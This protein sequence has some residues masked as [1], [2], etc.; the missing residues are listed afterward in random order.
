MRLDGAVTALRIGIIPFAD[1]EVMHA[2]V[3]GFC[4]A[5]GEA[6]GTPVELHRAPDYRSLVEAVE[7]GEV[8]V[9]WVPP[10]VAARGVRSGTIRPAAVA[11][12]NGSAGYSTAL[13]TPTTSPIKRPSDLRAARVAWVD[14]G[15]AGG[16][17][18]IRA[19][20][21][22]AGID[23]GG[24]F[25]TEVFMHSHV[26]VA[27]AV[28]DGHA[29][30]GAT[31]FNFHPGTTE[32]A[33]A[34]WKDVPR[35]AGNVRILAHAGPIPSDFL[36]VHHAVDEVIY[37]KLQLALIDGV[38]P[39]VLRLAR[40]L[41]GADAFAEPTN[42][43]IAMLRGLLASVEMPPTSEARAPSGPPPAAQCDFDF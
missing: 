42:D 17:L 9:A 28:V 18:V 35:A 33:R 15:S 12:R 31:Y 25:G 16:Y 43:H 5:V 6:L 4:A 21:R 37:R 13:I 19:A 3:A 14:D 24:A 30:V 36:A 7:D 27:E 38:P 8:S 29:D 22:E 23:L 1:S 2:R 41:F 40:Q 26:A 20:L 32:I 11:V 39:N 34:S 10:V